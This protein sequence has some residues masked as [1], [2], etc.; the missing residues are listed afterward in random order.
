MGSSPF[1]IR[2]IAFVVKFLC[3]G[4]P[5]PGGPCHDRQRNGGAKPLG[6]ENGSK[7]PKP[8]CIAPCLPS[9]FPA[10]SSPASSPWLSGGRSSFLERTAGRGSTCAQTASVIALLQLSAPLPRTRS[11]HQRP[12][13]LRYGRRQTNTFFGQRP[14]P[15]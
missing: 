1:K 14:S 6:A 12:D 4:T 2:P 5:G 15:A 13:E 8:L 10:S 7:A 11:C 3:K 9:R